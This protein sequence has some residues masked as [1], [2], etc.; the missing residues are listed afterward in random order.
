MMTQRRHGRSGGAGAIEF[1]TVVVV[2]GK[3]GHLPFSATVLFCLCVIDCCFSLMP[4]S[5]KTGPV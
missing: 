5:V 3:N 1:K 4:D 2:K